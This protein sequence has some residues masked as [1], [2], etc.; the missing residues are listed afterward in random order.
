MEGDG[1]V[2]AVSGEV[3][4]VDDGSFGV[5]ALVVGCVLD[6]LLDRCRCVLGKDGENGV[7]L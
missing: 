3:V 4:I 6:N 2:G 5:M 7:C 1:G